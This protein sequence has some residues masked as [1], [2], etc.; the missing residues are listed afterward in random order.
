MPAVQ[1]LFHVVELGE[2]VIIPGTVNLI[3]SLAHH[4][5]AEIPIFIGYAQWK[6]VSD[7][8]SRVTDH[9]TVF[10]SNLTVTVHICEFQV[11]RSDGSQCVFGRSVNVRF[12]LVYSVHFVTVEV[13]DG[14]SGHCVT[15]ILVTGYDWIPFLHETFYLITDG[16]QV[17]TDGVSPVT[18]LVAPS[19]CKFHTAVSDLSQITDARNGAGDARDFRKQVFGI[20]L[21]ENSFKV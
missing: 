4:F 20:L 12:R 17:G 11:S 6:S 21:V 19:S 7:I 15:L 1:P 16:R 5:N 14:V 8:G 2:V 18:D 9:R 3:T 13:A 10:R